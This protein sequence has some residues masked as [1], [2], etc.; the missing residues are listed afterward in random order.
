MLEWEKVVQNKELL[1]RVEELV[2]KVGDTFHDFP[3]E[4]CDELNR[5]TGN[6]WTGDNYIEYCAEY[7]DSWW[8]LE[9]VVFALFHEGDYPDKKEED[10]YAWNIGQSIDNDKDVISFYRFGKYRNESEKVSKYEDVDVRQLYKELLD[11]FPNWNNDVDSWEKDN[12]KTFMCS[13][14]ETYAYEKEIHIYNGYEQKFLNC[15]LT[16]LNEMEKD[17]FVKIVRKYCNHVA[18]DEKK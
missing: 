15:T 2:D 9:E 12:Y 10:W 13:N 7:W 3:Q 11:A 8:T 14:K 17:T 1:L 16:N 4:V 6:D 18:A 5:L